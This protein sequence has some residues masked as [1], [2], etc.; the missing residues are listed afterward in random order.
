ML[1]TPNR[2]RRT[3]PDE[4]GPYE[5]Q[6]FA[7]RFRVHANFPRVRLIFVN[8]LTRDCVSWKR[9]S[10]FYGELRVMT[11]REDLESVH[12]RLRHAVSL[13]MFDDDAGSLKSFSKQIGIPYRSLQDYLAGTRSPGADAL[14]KIAMKGIDVNW[15]L[16][17][18]KFNPATLEPNSVPLLTYPAASE[19]VGPI[20]DPEMVALLVKQS[21]KYLDRYLAKCVQE[22]KNP[23]SFLRLAALYR[24]VHA[25]L[26]T[27]YLRLA[28]VVP[29]LKDKEQAKEAWAELLA[30][31]LDDTFDAMRS[32]LEKEMHGSQAPSPNRGRR[33]AAKSGPQ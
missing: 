17:G 15:V 4:A 6:Q 28:E 33:S 32:E 30:R 16:T 20:R 23:P 8:N 1:A 24:E 11:D 27:I 10:D 7:A 18:E 26:S 25:H 22:G 19:F 9:V 14:Q 2:Q 13:K 31:T 3:L 29:T 5:E 21:E 12:G